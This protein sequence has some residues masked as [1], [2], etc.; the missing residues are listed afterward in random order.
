MG[1]GRGGEGN[2]SGV[3]E[4]VEQLTSSLEEYTRR[5]EN[6]PDETKRMLKLVAWINTWLERRGLG[7]VVVTGGFAVEVYTGRAYRTMYVDI[8]VDNGPGAARNVEKALARIGERIGR[9]YLP[10]RSM[11][12]VKSIDIPSIVG[13]LRQ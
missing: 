7:R 11:L 9:G 5:L 10:R 3:E 12:A 13:G 4:Y 1:E 8:I 2:S 6:E